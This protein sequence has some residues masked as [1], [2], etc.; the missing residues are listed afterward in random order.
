MDGCQAAPSSITVL[1]VF[2][3]PALL[4]VCRKQ[5]ILANPFL[6]QVKLTAIHIYL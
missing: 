2:Q 5:I 3:K 1:L 6:F 4:P